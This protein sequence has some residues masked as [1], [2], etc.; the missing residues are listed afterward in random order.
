MP[1]QGLYMRA[2]LLKH[3]VRFF[4]LSFQF[5][6]EKL[7]IFDLLIMRAF[8]SAGILDKPQLVTCS[9]VVNHTVTSMFVGVAR[10]G[11]SNSQ[12]TYYPCIMGLS[13]PY[14]ANIDTCM[15]SKHFL[16][17]PKKNIEH[18]SRQF[19]PIFAKSQTSNSIWNFTKQQL[20]NSGVR[21]YPS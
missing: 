16:R 7:K 20:H 11:W 13:H 4:W 3:S 2:L 19:S 14:C 8:L 17:Q 9:W 5:L 10:Q 21:F 18:D 1:H 6:I 12:R 15:V